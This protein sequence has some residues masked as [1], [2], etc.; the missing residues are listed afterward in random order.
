MIAGGLSLIAM[1]VAQASAQ[2]PT[3]P[4][5]LADAK[6][7][8]CNPPGSLTLSGSTLY[9]LS[10]Y[11]G[12]RNRGAVFSL[13]AAGGSPTILASFDGR[14]GAQPWGSVT[15]SGT[16]LYGMTS[17]GG[18]HDQ[19]TLFSIPVGGGSLTT[20]V[21]FDGTHGANPLGSLTLS[22]D[23]LT[24]YGTTNLGGSEN[25]GTIF[26][27]PAGGDTITILASFAGS[28]GAHP[29]GSLT[30]RG[31]TLY[32]VA[33]E[34]GAK[35]QGAIF[36]LPTGGVAIT[37]LASFEGHQGMCPTDSLTLGGSTLYGMTWVGGD[38]GK[39]TVYSVPLGGGAITLLASFD[40]SNGARPT[41][42]LT[43]SDSTLYGIADQGGANDNGIVFR[44]P[45]GGGDLSTLASF[46][47]RDRVCLRRTLTLSPDGSTLYGMTTRGGACVPGTL[48]S[49]AT[50]GQPSGQASIADFIKP[51]PPRNW[52][53]DVE[54]LRRV[55]RETVKPK[56]VEQ[57]PWPAEVKALLAW[58]QPVNGLVARIECLWPGTTAIVR[59]KNVSDQSLTVPMGNPR[60]EK[61]ASAF[62]LYVQQGSSPWRK[63]TPTSRD[64]G[65]PSPP[66]DREAWV[67]L[68]PGEDCIA[69][70]SGFDEQDSGESKRVKTVLR[71]SDE[72]VPGRWRGV[73][74]T[75]PW[76][77]ES[78]QRQVLAAGELLPFPN[79]V[80]PLNY[81]GSRFI[82][83]PPVVSDVEQL[84][85]S[86]RQLLAV[87]GI[88][89]PAG[90]C[91]EFQRR[92]RAE[93]TMPMRLLLAG[94]AAAA[95]SEEAG[96]FLLET[97]KDSDYVTVVN[98][99][100]ALSIA[101]DNSTSRP[102]DWQ[103]REPPDWLVE[104]SL[105]VLSDYRTVT[106]MENASFR[107]GKSP[108]IASCE[109]RRLT[110]ALGES[111]CRKAVPLL[112]ERITRREADWD[113]LNALGEIGDARAVPALVEGVKWG[114][115]D[116]QLYERAVYALA[117]LKARDALPALLDDIDYPVSIDALGQIGDPRALPA[118]RE[119]VAARGR[120][121]RDGK[122]VNPQLDGKR[123]YAAKVALTYLDDKDGVLHLAEM[124]DDPTLEKN[125]R[126]D[127]VLRLGR[128]PD[129]RAI[130]YLV[131]V[132][133]TDSDY[134]VVDLAI[135]DLA[136]LKYRAAVEG[137]IECFDVAFKAADLGKGEQVTPATYRN[138]IARSLQRLT[139]QSFGGDKRQWLRWWRKAGSKSAEL[140]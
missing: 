84:Y 110:F 50:H 57:K 126:Y 123:L 72:S 99:H 136:E 14:N 56:P 31:S 85:E 64:D 4:A 37:L 23:G 9:G 87:L 105:A 129:P 49:M 120:I 10:G 112:A 41:G 88:Y 40:G 107:S 132:I 80:P 91:K 73:L 60:G 29:M 130:P 95:G 34:G 46:S 25:L 94:V 35:R 17:L 20:R 102:P 43:F 122:S 121:V 5:S 131:K 6:T 30:L 7:S 65:P 82:N 28:N 62:E 114:Y 71:Q 124:L 116:E 78:S 11:G 89:E 44:L 97:M 1:L 47:E 63:A 125:D 13:P 59:L 93:K 66:S 100:D 55:I 26:S 118:L 27:I 128:R 70:V 32:G 108:I 76:T 45:L 106:G 33:S 15:L 137:L 52:Q 61:A 140:K 98:L 138:R 53:A 133:K 109:T 92:W 8:V 139:G 96:L 127:V 21:S 67:T 134:Y 39:G 74:E 115:F 38:K 24:L 16:T 58:S 69:L 90:V 104:L 22:P 113:T 86:N 117:Q 135:G 42:S 83:R 3:I 18:V 81:N 77:S 19:G 75:L 36:S 79:H 51:T 111:K 54:R 68:R 101:L 48:F 119:I 2:K 12:V 103:P